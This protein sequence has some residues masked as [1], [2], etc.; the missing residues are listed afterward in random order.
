MTAAERSLPATNRTVE[1]TFA[2]PR[3]TTFAMTP[4]LPGR[5]R[6]NL[7]AFIWD[8]RALATRW[9]NDA[10]CR[11]NDAVK[12]KHSASAPRTIS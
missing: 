6:L 1:T 3:G 7:R 11:G 9:A 2:L 5:Q 10:I 12:R 4:V 8:N